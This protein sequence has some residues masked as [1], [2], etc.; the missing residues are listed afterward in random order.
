MGK[1]NYASKMFVLLSE[2]ERL[3]YDIFKGW[4]LDGEN[5]KCFSQVLS[6]VNQLETQPPS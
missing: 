2:T 5:V 3:V 6:R 4:V 1:M